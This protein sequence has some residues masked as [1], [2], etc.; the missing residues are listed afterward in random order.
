MRTYQRAGLAPAAAGLLSFLFLSALILGVL[1]APDA[2]RA[3]NK[4]PPRDRPTPSGL[5][6]PRY[7]SLKFDKVNARAGPGDDH[8]LL[9]VYRVRGL[10]L[11]VVAETSEWRRVCDPDGGLAWVHKRTTDGRRM[12]MN[13]ATLPA[14]L[15]ARPKPVAQIDAYL[16]PRAMAA[17]VRCEKGWCRVRAD[18]ETGWVRTGELWGTN[19][20]V[21]CRPRPGGRPQGRLER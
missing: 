10:P 21:Q 18:D 4:G 8:R 13:T 5:P 15:R 2:A 14:P 1:A 20:A 3:A 17:L 11:Q 12:T 16:K 7:V 19:E 9:W 6:V